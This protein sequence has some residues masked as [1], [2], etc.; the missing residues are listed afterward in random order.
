MYIYILCPSFT[1]QHSDMKKPS[2]PSKNAA[3]KQIV[4]TARSMSDV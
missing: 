4:C 3:E 1:Q 2:K